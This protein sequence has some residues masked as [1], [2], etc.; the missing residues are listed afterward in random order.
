MGIAFTANAEIVVS[1]MNTE[2]ESRSYDQF[3]AATYVEYKKVLPKLPTSYTINWGRR[4]SYNGVDLV[5]V[6]GTPVYAW[7]DGMVTTSTMGWNGGYGTYIIISHPSGTDTLYAH[8]S[9]LSA[10]KGAEV[11]KGDLIGLM[12]TTGRSTG[13]HLHFEVRGAENPFVR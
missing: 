6:C 13:C 2:N 8:L 9:R 11:R 1:P 10:Q 3:V 12:G 5:N 4:H 7:D